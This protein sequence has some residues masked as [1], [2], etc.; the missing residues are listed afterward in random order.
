[1]T[2]TLSRPPVSRHGDN[3]SIEGVGLLFL[4][5]MSRFWLYEI[6]VEYNSLSSFDTVVAYEE[7]ILI[8]YLAGGLGLAVSLMAKFCKAHFPLRTWSNQFLQSTLSTVWLAP[9]F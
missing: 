8:H 6:E 9:V 1:M 4:H 2:N 3:L 5:K 7:L